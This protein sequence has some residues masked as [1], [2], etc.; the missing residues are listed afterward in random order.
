MGN[1]S[2]V[3]VVSD[4]DAFVDLEP[5][6][7]DAVE[8][9]GLSHPFLRHEWMRSWWTCFGAGRQLHI[10]IAR[11]AGTITAI[12][13][14]FRES[15][16]IHGVPVRRI[17]FLHNDHTPRTDFVVTGPPAE[18]Y[19]AI[20]NALL[21]ERA[22]WDVVQLN[23][24]PGDS[25]TCK[26]M[27]E[28]AAADGCTVGTWRGGDSPFLALTATWDEYLKGRSAKFRQNLRNRLSR[29]SRLGE[30]SLEVLRD[31][32]SISR[33]FDDVWRLEDSGWK[34][35][36]GTAISSDGTLRHF[37]SLLARRGGASG[38]LR[39]LFLTVDGRRIAVSYGSCYRNRL[40]LFKTG[41][42]AEYAAC[43]P[44][45][46]LTYF[47]I[48]HAF[49]EGMTEVDFLGDAEPWKLDWTTTTRRHDW[50]FAFSNSM[51]ARLAHWLK[52]RLVPGL[53]ERRG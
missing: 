51:R 22:S 18:S 41:Y 5:E 46:M 35:N 47:A 53:R 20:W 49:D 40:L 17:C 42:D 13:P 15:A 6:W 4:L 28:L 34:R 29:L 24:L 30:P 50:L 31:P 8:R 11:R 37:Y 33:A 45:K 14:L 44:F 25:L 7:N 39:L 16:R 23:Q 12:A 9:A 38:W 32:V 10:L 21:D 3:D 19:R 48:R 27:S 2:S 43:S 1:T 36:A 26:S 52:F